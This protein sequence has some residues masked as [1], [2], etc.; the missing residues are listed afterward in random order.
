MPSPAQPA[1]VHEGRAQGPVGDQGSART[2]GLR[3]SALTGCIFSWSWAHDPTRCT[4][5]HLRQGV[6]QRPEILNGG[7]YANCPIRD[8]DLGKWA[9]HATVC[10]PFAGLAIPPSA[11]QRSGWSTCCS[12]AVPQ[13]HRYGS[14]RSTATDIIPNHPFG[15][16]LCETAA[17]CQHCLTFIPRTESRCI[18]MD[19][20]RRKWG[21]TNDSDRTWSVNQLILIFVGS[22]LFQAGPCV[23]LAVTK[24]CRLPAMSSA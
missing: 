22:L 10:F 16:E 9:R 14:S 5:A 1:P 11:F 21:R 13:P 3:C 7:R 12:S 2:P 4:A 15:R 17:Q 20:K 24:C 6:L 8:T 23:G 19:E 18:V